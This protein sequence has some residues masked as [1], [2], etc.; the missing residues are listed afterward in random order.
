MLRLPAGLESREAAARAAGRERPARLIVR[1][2]LANREPLA[3]L[4]SRHARQ[5]RAEI[6]PPRTEKLQGERLAARSTR[7]RILTAHSRATNGVA[8]LWRMGRVEYAATVGAGLFLRVARVGLERAARAA[9]RAAHICP[10]SCTL[11]PLAS[12]NVPTLRPNDSDRSNDVQSG[13]LVEPV[14]Y[15]NSATLLSELNGV[16]SKFSA[17]TT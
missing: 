15:K 16:P 12:Q 8:P 6:A 4:G 10:V 2:R 13:L 11:A 1:A 5:S 7:A 17:S 14:S 9:S 3:A